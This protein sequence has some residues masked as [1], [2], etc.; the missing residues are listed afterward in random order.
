MSFANAMPFLVLDDAAVS[1]TPWLISLNGGEKLANPR[2]L[3]GWDY[4]SVLSVERRV[5]IDFPAASAQLAIPAEQL[6]ISLIVAMGT[7]P[8][9]LPRSVDVQKIFPIDAETNEID[10]SIDIDSRAL[11]QRLLLRTSCL[12]AVPPKTASI[13]SPTLMGARLWEDAGDIALEG[14]SPRFPIDAI[15]FHQ[16]FRG[17]I[18][19]NAL[20]Y[21]Q[22]MSADMNRDIS[23][24]LRLYVNKDK[25]DFMERLRLLDALTMQ[26]MLAD[27]MGQLVGRFLHSPDLDELVRSSE[28][29]SIAKQA[30][31]WFETAFP[32]Q[33][34]AQV[35]ALQ[36]S[37]PGEFSAAI[38]AAA[39]M[40]KVPS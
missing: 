28:R 7:G 14:G 4:S 12:L 33:S 26:A 24:A 32:D 36:E 37:K 35:R 15:S 16:S 10:I 6:K 17:R 3:K 21:L 38:Q 34:H 9:T 30:Q 1:A 8:G 20:W 13:L 11:S 25:E 40:A 19:E 23:G 31:Q 29:G 5:R 22:W 39:E 27:I 18:Q 2:M